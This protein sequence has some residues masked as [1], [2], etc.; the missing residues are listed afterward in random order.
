MSASN[1]S[2]DTGYHERGF[3]WFSSLPPGNCEDS[4]TPNKF[5]EHQS[6]CHLTLYSSWCWHPPPPEKK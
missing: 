5:A 1:L 6:P 3:S 2:W 4:G